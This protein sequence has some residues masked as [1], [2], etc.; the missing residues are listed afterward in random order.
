[1]KT[2]LKSLLCF[3]VAIAFGNTASLTA[4]DKAAQIAKGEKVYKAYCQTCHQANGQGL[5]TVYPPL[6]GSDYI[7]S[8]PKKEII[9]SVVNGLKGEI[10]VNGKKFN[11]VMV[12]L[13]KNYTDEDAAN[14]ITYVYNTWGNPGGAVTVA[15]VKALRGK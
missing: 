2:F 4:Q 9:K 1:M 15:E 7:K 12:A 14:V 8:K 6:A 5:S 3:G 13:P 11:G 10:T